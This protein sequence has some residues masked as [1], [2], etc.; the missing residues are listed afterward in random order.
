MDSIVSTDT[1]P[2]RSAP[3]DPAVN[4]RQVEVFL[5]VVDQGSF[6][7]AARETYVT[8]STISQHIAALEEEL[9]AQLLERSR[10]G[11]RVTE[12]G[13]ILL[14]HARRIRG[15]LRATEEAFR[16]FRGLEDAVLRLGVSTIPA[17]YLVPPVLARLCRDFP[18]LRVVVV[19]GDSKETLERIASRDV[20]AG[21]V[22]SRFDER[23][24][25]WQEVGHDRIRLVVAPGHPWAGRAP[26]APADLL[27]QPLIGREPGSGTGRTVTAAL[28]AAGV[29]I[30]RL[31]V[32]A[33]M[34]SGEAIRAAA[35]AG[36]GAAFL[37]EL[38][39]RREVER[40]ELV[41]VPV[42]GIDITR[43]FYL[44]RQSAHDPTPAAAAFWDAMR[45]EHGPR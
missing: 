23:G 2:T 9:G 24:L 45:T 44:V 25:A 20:E 27:E 14:K 21:V 13:K 1:V 15:E 31:R 29:D 5:A 11:V 38:L 37:S 17:A 4:L 8:Q 3:G 40:G 6:S 39:I 22:G 34:E 16:R 41:V 43:P 10:N 7:A 12:A 36:L 32:R 19:Q 30:G 28:E 18:T 35:L 26:I 42:T 33:E